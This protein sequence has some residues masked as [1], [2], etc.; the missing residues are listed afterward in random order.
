MALTPWHKVATPR[1]DLRE[2]KPLD[3]SR[4]AV[5]LDQVRD[6]NAPDDYKNPTQF[7]ERT[8]LTKNLTSMAAEVARR[9]SGDATVSAV[10]NMATQFGGGKTHALTLLYHLA[11]N[12]PAASSWTG[13]DKILEEAGLDAMPKAATAVFVGTE[14]DSIA[15]RGGDGE[16]TRKTPWG[17]IAYQLGGMESFNLIRDHEQE[18]VAPGGDVIR[19][20]LPRDRPCII[21]MDE[22]MNYV[23]RFRKYGLS[24]Q[25]Y[26]FL[27]NLSGVASGMD[28]VVLVVSIPA[29]E[30]E[31]TSEDE[32]DYG[33]L[34][35]LL[36]RTSKAVIMSADADTAEIIRR[37]LFEWGS[38][39]NPTAVSS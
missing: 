14:F 15:G 1:Q 21:L 28:N 32:Q 29:S 20:L 18:Q 36:D 35:K 2:G 6:G 16:P 31:M 9:L 33:R 23:N 25:L 5:H 27:Q 13:V 3:A 24:D 4:F 7:F 34:K 22:L 8:Y 17:E 10:Y 39:M 30:M 26:D 12:G 19:K 37:R 11:Q 38:Q